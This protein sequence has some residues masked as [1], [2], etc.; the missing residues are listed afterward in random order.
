MLN[1]FLLFLI[2]FAVL[3]VASPGSAIAHEIILKD[4]KI[5]KGT[6]ISQSAMRVVVKLEGDEEVTKIDSSDIKKIRKSS[7]YV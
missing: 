6:V 5:L 3:C 7:R 4:G 2:I 1:R